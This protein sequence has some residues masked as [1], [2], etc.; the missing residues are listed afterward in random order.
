M[1]GITGF[2]SLQQAFSENTLRQITQTI[3]HRGPDADGFFYDGVC[4]LG[5]RRLSILDLSAGANQPMQSHNQRYWIA[6]N[7]E[8]YN[9]RELS[10]QVD[11]PLKTTSDTEVILELFSK[12]HLK[13]IYQFNGMFAFGLYDREAQELYVVR[14]RIGVKP[15]YYYWDG[16]NFAFASELKALLT[17][18]NFQKELNETA[19]SA[20]LHL[21]YV[22]APHSIYKHIY[23]LPAGSW[24]RVGKDGIH[25]SKFWNINEKVYDETTQS[26]LSLLNRLPEAKQQLK[27]LLHSSVNYRL[28]SDVPVGVFLSGGIDSSLVAAI[29]TQEANT[30]MQ[31]FSIGFHENKFNE[32]PYAKAVADALG[33]RHHEFIVS[34]EEAKKIIP[35]LID[36]YDEPYADSSAIPTLLLSRLASEQVKVVLGGDGGDELFLGY[37]MY[38][39]AERLRKSF[40]RGFRHPLSGGFRLSSAPRYQKAAAMLNYGRKLEPSHIFSQEQQFFSKREL[41]TLL[42]KPLIPFSYN[43]PTLPRKL[44]AMDEQAFFD[45]NYYLPDDLLVKV[46]RAT[47]RYGLEARVPLLDYRVIEFGLNLN[48]DLKYHNKTTKYLL[49]QLLYDYLPAKMFD[50]PKQG[51]A[52]PLSTWLRGD[53]KYLLDEYL[54]PDIVKHYGIVKPEMVE[55]FKAKYLKGNLYY[56]NRVWVLM[57]LHQFLRK[58]FV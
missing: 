46:D 19:I 8:V 11:T 51:F 2:F 29:A 54:N 24:L 28:I 42:L 47:M 43:T 22:P 3:A 9:Y 40:W 57:L 58:E 21:G 37:G 17:L 35:H 48:P 14:D 45:L 6:Y 49:K 7:G 33:T 44:G 1:C 30:K 34:V 36:M 52:I 18:P 15:I 38:Q 50:R 16:Q 23:K 53:L 56:Y 20:F 13:S 55:M 10:K 31:T 41:D 12:M 4:G 26:K 5:H 25:E 39:W 32:A 27:K